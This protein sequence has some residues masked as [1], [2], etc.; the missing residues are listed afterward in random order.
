M[1]STSEAYK[2]F[3]YN[4]APYVMDARHFLPVALIKI[5]DAAARGISNYTA[6]SQA[7][8]SNL[9]GLIDDAYTAKK[10]WG[11]AEPYQFLLSKPSVVFMG[12]ETSVS[13]TVYGWA[14]EAMSDANC[15]IDEILTVTYTQAIST[16]GR[17]LFFDTCYDCVPANFTLSYYSHGTLLLTETVEDNKLYTYTSKQGVSNYDQLIMHFTKLSKPNRRIHLIEDIPGVYLSYAGENITSVTITHE[18]DLFSEELVVSEIELAVE[19][20]SKSMDILNAE[21][22]EAYLQQ[23]QP[24]D[25]YLRL[26]YPDNSYEDILICKWE[27]ASWKSNKG[28]LEEIFTIKDPLDKLTQSEYIKGTLPTNTT[29]MYDLAA[30]VLEDAGITNYEVDHELMN[31]YCRGCL[32][33]AEHK[34]LLRMIAQASQAVVV[35][36]PEGGVHVKYVSPLVYGYN[37]LEDG[38]FDDTVDTPWSLSGADFSEDYIYTGSN[39]IIF[40]EIDGSIAQSYSD[41]VIGHLYYVR[42]YV[43]P[44]EALTTLEG[45]AGFYVNDALVTVNIQEANLLP[46]EWTLISG[47]FTASTTELVC[48]IKSTLPAGVVYVGGIMLIDL[49]RI[50]GAGNEPTQKW[51]DT[52]IRFIADTMLVPRA[53]DPMPVD[54]LDYS[55]LIDAP[56]IELRDPVKSVET[57]I[58]SYIAETEISEVYKGTRLIAGTE[59]F[60]IRFNTLAKN[61]TIQLNAVDDNG[62]VLTDES[63]TLLESTFYSKAA[64]LKVR[65]NCSVQ[66]IVTGNKI[67]T[68]TTVYKV[69]ADIAPSLLAD[70]T[71]KVIDNE[72]ITYKVVAEDVTSYAIYW[73]GRRYLYDFDW[74]QNPAIE[75]LDTVKV[76]DDFSN[77]KSVLITE[78]NLDYENGILSGSSKGVAG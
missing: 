61:C 57:N 55:I 36:T 56:E 6:S 75:V 67:S 21:G 30:A 31:I 78:Q 76:H 28:S 9:S 27:L 59:T 53:K 24:I 51:C 72:L 42:F 11:T 25:L 3:V 10:T 7:F 69:S 40:S 64:T 38:A 5:I 49:T 19:N 71:E 34:E 17:T 66:I 37:C 39:S 1:I 22:F 41:G 58:Y 48:M 46:E 54:S 50:Y 18:I 16:V 63:V 8:Y 20:V 4:K 68:S 43:F 47:C 13:S 62:D 60:N 52:N 32:P 44:T 33:I 2:R 73:Y 14:G 23:H 12:T 45:S 70:A 35:P 15:N 65:A 26:I 29:T 74:R 77:D